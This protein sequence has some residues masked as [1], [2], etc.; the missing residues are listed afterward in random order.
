[1]HRPYGTLYTMLNEQAITPLGEA[2]SNAELFRRLAARMGFD[3][4]CFRQSDEDIAREAHDLTAPVNATLDFDTLRRN[5]WRRLD[6]PERFA[7][8]AHGNFPTPSGRCEFESASAAAKGWSAVPEFIP[9][10]ESALGDPELAARFPLMLLTPPA[11]HYLN[12][13]FSSIESLVREVGAPWVEIHP[14]DAAARGIVHGDRVRVFNA[15]GAFEVD[16]RVADKVRPGVL[17]APSIWWQKKS[18]DGENANAVTSDGQTDIGG[19][20][21][22]YDTAVDVARLAPAT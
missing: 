20:A 6:V 18:A 14:A 4:A 13:T 7:P 1:V 3:E 2:V 10:R 16:A 12:S 8:F 22:Y 19:G 5:G 17:V 9:P 21:T 15:R 11:R